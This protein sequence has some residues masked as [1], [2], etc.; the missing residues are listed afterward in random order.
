MIREGSKMECRKYSEF[1]SSNGL[2]ESTP[3]Y[4]IISL[5]KD[6]RAW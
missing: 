6:L 5:G 2:T 3:V 1:I 4:R